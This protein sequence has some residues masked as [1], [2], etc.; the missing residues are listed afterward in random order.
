MQIRQF[1]LAPDERIRLNWEIRGM[2][3]K[4]LEWR[5]TLRQ[6]RDNH[7]SDRLRLQE[8]AQ[9]MLAEVKD[10]NSLR[11]STGNGIAYSPAEKHLT[12]MTGVEQ[13]GQAVEA[14]DL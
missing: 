4:A 5:E 8:V 7:L 1:L 13:A 3:L 9:A 12:T 11:Q 14:G 10:I 6:P 2:A